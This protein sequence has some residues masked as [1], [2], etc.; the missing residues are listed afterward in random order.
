MSL[1]P[2]RGHH[3]YIHLWI[4]RISIDT[5][6]QAHASIF[7]HAASAWRR[8]TTTPEPKNTEGHWGAASHNMQSSSLHLLAFPYSST[9]NLNSCTFMWI[10]LNMNGVRV[11]VSSVCFFAQSWR[12]LDVKSK[13]NASVSACWVL[14]SHRYCCSCCYCCCEQNI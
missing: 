1:C 7:R 6:T 2:P 5:Y 13:G 10:S 11:R 12:V 9:L 8:D 3:L 14:M 4:S